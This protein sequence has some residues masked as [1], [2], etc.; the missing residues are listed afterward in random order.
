[1]L[2]IA[3]SLD[4][5]TAEQTARGDINGNGMIDIADVLRVMQYVNGEISSVRTAPKA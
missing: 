1:M 3:V 4:T 2:R 5:P